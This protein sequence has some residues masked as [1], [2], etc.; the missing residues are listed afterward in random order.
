M[1]FTKSQKLRKSFIILTI[2]FF[3][4]LFS[5]CFNR[6]TASRGSTTVSFY[7][8]KETVEKI[9]QKTLT[10]SRSARDADSD[11]DLFIDVSLFGRVEQTKTAAVTSDI[12][13]DFDEVPVGS[14]VYAKAKIY[15]FLDAERTEKDV[16]YNGTSATIVVRENVNALSINLKGATLLVTFASDSSTTFNFLLLIL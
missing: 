10:G 13:I 3:A 16:I 9:V 14:S 15:K 4:V 1:L 6:L 5:S 12:Q 7:M 8:D 2:V 11:S